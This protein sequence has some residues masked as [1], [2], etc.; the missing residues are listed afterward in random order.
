MRRLFTTLILAI[1]V[2]AGSVNAQ[3][4][5]GPAVNGGMTYS[6]NFVVDD[7]SRYYI[8]NGMSWA[9]GGGLDILYQFDDNIRAHIGGGVTMRNFSLQAPAGRDGLSFTEINESVLSISVP[10]TIHYRFP[11]KEEGSTYFNIIAGHQL[12]ITMEDSSV[13]KTPSTLVDSGNGYTQHLYHKMKRILPTVLLGAGMDFQSESG[14]VLN[15]SLVWGIGTGKVFKGNIQEWEVLN[16]DYDPANAEADLPEEF[17]EHY[18][19]W[20]LRGSTLTLRLSYWFNLSSLF[21]GGDDAGGDE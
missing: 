12:D 15:V 11:L 20:A 3:L 17:P 2:S 4:L 14:N 21:S 19:D 16:G 7:T 18:F 1:L 6:K 13:I 10:M 8:A 9:A 5:L